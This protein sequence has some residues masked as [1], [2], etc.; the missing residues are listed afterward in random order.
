MEQITM[1]SD[2]AAS[3]EKSVLSE[4]SEKKRIVRSLLNN[5]GI[6]SGG[7]ILCCVIAV[8]TTDIQ[9][10]S[11]ADLA[12][13]GLDFFILMFL[14]YSMYINCSDSGMRAGLVTNTYTDAYREYETVKK[15]VIDNG[16]HGHLGDFCREW[17]K[18]ELKQSRTSVI[19]VVGIS[20][21]E[22]MDKY[23]G[24]DK[25]EIL[26]LEGFSR[27]QKRA[28]LRANGIKPV[29][30]TPDMMMKRGRGGRRRAPLGTSPELKKGIVFGSKF[31]TTIIFMLALSLVAFEPVTEQTWEVF[32]TCVVKLVSV[33]LSGFNGYKFGY[34]NIVFDTVNYMDD[35]ADLLGQAI[36]YCDA[37]G[38]A[39]KDGEK[40]YTGADKV[41]AGACA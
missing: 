3:F 12:D 32:V 19:A 33:A 27:V 9:I 7:L 22:Y 15:K 18:E 31:F 39:G 41:R 14:S 6:V 2:R 40:H 13:L 4:N 16:L 11:L 34:E 24:L 17:I 5:I 25:H 20:Y 38:K 8:V 36:V 28:I 23:V 1:K 30:L 21:E 37:N 10:K 26:Q 29:H 35:Q